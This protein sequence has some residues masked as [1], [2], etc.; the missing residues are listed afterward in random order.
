MAKNA[1]MVREVFDHAL[2]LPSVAERRAYLDQACAGDLELRQKVEGLLRAHDEAGSFL[3]KPPL[4]GPATGPYEGAGGTA[5]TGPYRPGSTPAGHAASEAETVPPATAGPAVEGPGT[6]L[7]PYRLVREVGHGGMG[8]VY[9]AEQEQPVRRQVALKIIKPGMDH[10]QVV[11]RFEAERQALALMDHLNIAKVLDAGATP[12]GRPY[13]VME[14]VQGVPITKYCDDNRLTVRERLELFVPVC[15]AIQ[16]AHQKGVIHRDIKPSNVLVTLHEGK[17]FPKV[18]D[19]GVAKA[20]EQPLI[21]QSPETQVGQVVG[22]LKYMSPEQTGMSGR[23]IDTRSD[24][25]SLGVLLYELLTGTT[26]LD[27]ARLKG[28][29]PFDV[30][31]MIAEEEP[32]RP[33]VRV[34]VAGERSAEGA[35]RRRTEP[36]RLARLLRGDLDWITA[37]ALEKDRDRRYE[38]AAGLAQDVRRYLS[39]EPVEA[40]PPSAAYR[41]G[42]FAR[43]HR[44]LAAFGASLST[45]LLLGIVGLTV[46]LLV[47]NHARQRAETAQQEAERSQKQTHAALDMNDAVIQVLLRK[48]IRFEAAEKAILEKVLADYQRAAPSSGDSEGEWMLEAQAQFH[49]ANLA[50]LIDR[51]DVAEAGYSRAVKLYE[52]LAAKSPGDSETRKVLARTHFN[53]GIHFEGTKNLAAAEAAFRIAAKLHERLLAD[54]PDDPGHRSDLADDLNDLGVILRER[55][56]LAAAGEAFRQ[57][58]DM[59]KKLVADY[60]GFLPYRIKLA[61]NYGNLGNIV[62]DQGQPAEALNWYGK[63]IELLGPLVAGRRPPADAQGYLH[64]AHWDRANAL[65]QLGRHAEAVKDWKRA[66]A[67]DDGTYRDSIQLFLDAAQ[68]EERL[69]TIASGT[70]GARSGSRLYA[71]ARCFARAAKAAEDADEKK[72]CEWYAGRTLALLGQARDAGFFRDPQR[73]EEFKKDG[74][75]KAL[76]RRPEFQKFIA[77]LKPGNDSK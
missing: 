59:G 70:D 67:L 45:L 34:A 26:P 9:L 7:G 77:G 21:E 30:L 48:K 58:I 12:E 43:K 61:A 14:L 55:D 60:P 74:D 62:R 2:E 23:G 38:T 54:H 18:I 66:L 29:A 3:E 65:G 20:I 17:P 35:A 76:G 64:N 71:A 24:V 73:L 41:F 25:Y 19:F 44:M 1:P 75:L 47:V 40:R 39:D 6:R 63:D 10:G 53:S 27:G 4:S 15:Q 33:S 57:A 32:P 8:A 68:E 5:S 51:D 50:A 13:F 49:I 72:L 52:V 31:R 69:K 46:G 28:A 16:H 37:K 11:A 42:K 22:T 36:A 56:Q